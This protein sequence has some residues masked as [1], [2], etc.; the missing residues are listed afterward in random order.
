MED[1]EH[2]ALQIFSS[3]GFSNNLPMLF[4]S[5]EKFYGPRDTELEHFSR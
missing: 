1:K 2:D 5:W 3:K 4:P